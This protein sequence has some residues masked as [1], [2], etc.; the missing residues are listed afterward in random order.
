MARTL[1]VENGPDEPHSLAAYLPARAA[2]WA[3]IVQAHDLQP[4]PLTELLGESHH[5]ADLCLAY[6]ATRPPAP[7]FVSTVRIKQAGFTETCNTET[8]VCYWLEDLMT[9]R[10]LPPRG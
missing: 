7:T 2:L 4:V 9:R 5:Y 8:S 10:I 6:G 1:G 3:D